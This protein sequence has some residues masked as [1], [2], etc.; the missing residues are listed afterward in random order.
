[1]QTLSYSSEKYIQ[2]DSPA[3]SFDPH[4]GLICVG[5]HFL[6]QESVKELRGRHDCIKAGTIWLQKNKPLRRQELHFDGKCGAFSS[7]ELNGAPFFRQTCYLLCPNKA[8]ALGS[9]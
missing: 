9:C 5:Y 4:A 6:H 8:S 2:R 3:N 1:M 7:R